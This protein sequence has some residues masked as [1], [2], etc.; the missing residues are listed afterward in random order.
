MILIYLRNRGICFERPGSIKAMMTF[1]HTRPNATKQ[2]MIPLE[3]FINEFMQFFINQIPFLIIS[4][5]F[6]LCI[7]S[8]LSSISS[9]KFP[10]IALFNSG[11]ASCKVLKPA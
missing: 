5:V 2:R 6:T 11:P 9:S 1:L 7:G 10:E 4:L 8:G 3:I